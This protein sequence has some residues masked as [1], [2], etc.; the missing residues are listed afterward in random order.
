MSEM[1]PSETKPK[2]MVGRSLAIAIGIICIVLV[3]GLVL[4]FE[5]YISGLNS[6]I[7]DKDGTISLLNSQLGQANTQLDNLNAIVGM[8]KSTSWASELT[9]DSVS[10]GWGTIT[11]LTYAGY[12]SVVVTSS[13]T[14]ST[15]VE[16]S[17]S[18]SNGMTYDR[19]V[20]LNSNQN[21]AWFPVLPA[22]VHFSVNN[23]SPFAFVK[24]SATYFY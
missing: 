3:V 19:T 23:L 5:S 12:V 2:K 11:T 1:K 18:L 6:Q 7:S 20:T 24:V 17:Y 16:L 22:T 21:S 9:L 8:T 15:S 4:V 10:N 14:F 13:S